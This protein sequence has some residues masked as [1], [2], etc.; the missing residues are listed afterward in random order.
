MSVRQAAC[1]GLNKLT[2]S[3][4]RK[5]AAVVCTDQSQTECSDPSVEGQLLDISAQ[6][7][8]ATR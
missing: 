3:Q 4:A 7:K 1:W 2:G 6:V 5:Q 8:R